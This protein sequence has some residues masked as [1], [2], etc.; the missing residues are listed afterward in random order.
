MGRAWDGSAA[1]KD[2][3]AM[4]CVHPDN[5]MYGTEDQVREWWPEQAEGVLRSASLPD[6]SV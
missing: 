1:P 4:C 5:D 3:P 2:E 6:D